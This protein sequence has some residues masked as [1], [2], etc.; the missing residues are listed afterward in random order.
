MKI[1][2]IVFRGQNGEDEVESTSLGPGDM[3]TG[4][5]YQRP[6]FPTFHD[7]PTLNVIFSL[8]YW[9]KNTQFFIRVFFQTGSLKPRK[10]VTNMRWNSFQTMPM[11]YRSVRYMIYRLNG[12]GL[13]MIYTDDIQ[14]SEKNI[15]MLGINLHLRLQPTLYI[16]QIIFNKF[17]FRPNSNSP[18]SASLPPWLSGPSTSLTSLNSHWRTRSF[19][20]MRMILTLMLVLINI[21]K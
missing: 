7:M 21:L 14:V 6:I 20:L 12:L 3:P 8:K 16:K 1:M 18:P 11:T 2:M 13:H 10:S 17:S 4:F 9:L 15:Q 19:E 5:F